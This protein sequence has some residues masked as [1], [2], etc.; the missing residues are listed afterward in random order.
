MKPNFKRKERRTPDRRLY[1]PVSGR[2]I[3]L[4]LVSDPVYAARMYGEGIALEPAA[5]LICAPSAGTL[6]L[7]SSSCHA[8]GLETEAGEKV[9]VHVGFGTSELRGKGFEVLASEGSKVKC[10]QPILRLDRKFFEMRGTDLTTLMV[11]PAS[12]IGDYKIMES[13]S[14]QAGKT[15][16][17]ER[18]A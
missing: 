7:I 12:R 9:Y 11:I 16:L 1:A 18:K 10:G 17:M 15:P 3:P 14:A 2:A 4:N 13:D 6:C 5:D 8:F